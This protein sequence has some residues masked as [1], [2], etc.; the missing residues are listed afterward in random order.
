[1]PA[2]LLLPGSIAADILFP[3]MNEQ[4]LGTTAIN[5]LRSK[6]AG[7]FL[8]EGLLSTYAQIAIGLWAAFGSRGS[9]RPA[10]TF[11]AIFGAISL[12][13]ILGFFMGFISA[14]MGKTRTVYDSLADIMEVTG[15]YMSGMW[16]TIFIFALYKASRAISRKQV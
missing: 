6:A 14:M 12:N 3:D 2:L 10:I 9:R 13:G 15:P 5:V 4:F 1:M 8:A 11:L 7:W 16:A